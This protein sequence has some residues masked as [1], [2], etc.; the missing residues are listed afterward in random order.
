MLQLI[1]N[2][3][4]RKRWRIGCPNISN[5]LKELMV[6]IEDIINDLQDPSITHFSVFKKGFSTATKYILY[7]KGNK[8]KYVLKIY[9]IEKADRRSVEFDLLKRHYSHNVSCPLPVKFGI[10]EEQ[11]ICYMILSYL[12]G[13]SGDTSLPL[14]S[15]EEQYSL[16][17]SAGEELKKIHVI[18]PQK[19]FN[20]YEKR[21][22]KYQNKIDECKRLGLTFYKQECIESYIKDNIYLLKDSPIH[23]QHDDFHPQNMIVKDDGTISIIDFDSYDWGDPFEEFFKLPKFTIHVSAYFAKGQVIGYFNHK[24]PD[25]FWRKYNLFVAL[26]QHA[27]QI[28][29]AAAN[30]LQAVEERTR[31]IVET[32]DFANNG[33]PEWYQNTIL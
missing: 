12:D 2:G 5:L 11:Q 15:V 14:K 9:G 13:V 8:S 26:N 16:G 33:A 28:A 4:R 20:W 19:P 30:N 27:S 31:F 3:E 23:F 1:P 24:I 18:T 25:D 17:I 32:H 7:S 10:N 6:K 22:R 29:G 21:M